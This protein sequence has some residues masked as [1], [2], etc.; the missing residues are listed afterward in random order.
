MIAKNSWFN[1]GMKNFTSSGR[2]WVLIVVLIVVI[3]AWWFIR[4]DPVLVTAL[5]I[6]T[7][8]TTTQPAQPTPTTPKPTT[9]GT[10]KPSTSTAQKQYYNAKLG[11]GFSYPSNL[12][13]SQELAQTYTTGT[14]ALELGVYAIQGTNHVLYGYIAVNQ[15]IKDTAGPAQQKITTSKTTVAGVT[16]N[17]RL[18]TDAQSGFTKIDQFFTVGNNTYELQ[19]EYSN[20]QAQTVANTITKSFYVR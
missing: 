20:A 4:K 11:F 16:S 12:T 13:I 3:G 7:I 5:P 6:P 15:V 8:G 1:K 2:L 10:K 14:Q 9:S 17:Q 19:F 18:I